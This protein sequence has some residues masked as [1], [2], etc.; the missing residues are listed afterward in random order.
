[1]DELRTHGERGKPSV[2]ASTRHPRE[3]LVRHL[4]STCI[5]SHDAIT[6]SPVVKD[7]VICE[8]GHAGF[9]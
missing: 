2:R 5:T 9:I 3:V 6:P 1:M 4:D 8:C 7:F